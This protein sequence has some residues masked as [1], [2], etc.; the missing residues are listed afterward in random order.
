MIIRALIEKVSMGNDAKSYCNWIVIPV[1]VYKRQGQGRASVCIAARSDC[2]NPSGGGDALSGGAQRYHVAGGA[3]LAFCIG[4]S[5][6]SHG[7]G[8]LRQRAP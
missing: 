8:A 5:R 4:H 2:L 7:C 6:H 3:L 1:D